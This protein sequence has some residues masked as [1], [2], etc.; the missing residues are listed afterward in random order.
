MSILQMEQVSYQYAGSKK[1]VLKKINMAFEPGKLYVVVGRSGAGKSTLLAL[2]SGLDL[3][4]EGNMYYEGQDMKVLDRD[5]YRAKSI[6]VIFQ[7]Y[8]LLTN[9]TALENIVLSM[10]ISGSREKDKREYALKLLEK[11]GID[12]DTA[13]RKVLKLSGGEQQRVGIARA[14]AHEPAIIIADEPTGNLDGD[15]EK[16]IME[17]LR[18]LAHD[19]GKCVIVVTH[20]KAVS[21][22]ADELWGL[23]A[24]N[25]VFLK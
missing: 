16:N 22:Y 6:G 18:S 10:N 12:R 23:N 3:C 20:S 15:T 14:I 9:A 24:G 5:G 7:G 8:N 13:V 4:T 11:V 1:K 19:Q 17:I 2:L 21:K 25:L